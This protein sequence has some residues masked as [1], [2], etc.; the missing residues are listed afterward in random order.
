M[1]ILVT[2]GRGFL[3]RNLVAHLHE[4]KDCETR[5]FDREDST[6]DLK[7]WLLEADVIFHLAG[8]N[9][10]QNP[11]DFETGNAELTSS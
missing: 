11:I 1:R 5:I 9:R 8:I 3:G 2:G 6:E 7:N 10:P 4:R